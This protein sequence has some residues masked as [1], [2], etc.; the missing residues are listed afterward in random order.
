M[1]GSLAIEGNTLSLDQVTALL[2]GKRVAGP[3]REVREVQNALS[4]Y[5]QLPSLPP[6][7]ERSLLLM[8]RA[9][10]EGLVTDAGRW[11]RGNVGIFRRGKLRHLAP[12]AARV[13][14]LMRALVR[15]LKGDRHT[16]TLVRAC[17]AHY[18][19]QFIHP[20][21]DGNGRVGRLWQHV[22]LA[23]ESPVFALLPVESLIRRRQRAYYAA[24]ARADA[25]GESTPFI[26]FMLGCL[27]DSLEELI[28]EFRSAPKRREDR[29]AEAKR[30]LGAKWFSRKEYLTLFKSISTATAS[31][32]LQQGTAE[33][34]L[35]SR[36]ERALMR[37]R[38]AI[39]DR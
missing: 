7:S 6:W 9:L 27:V 12:P 32:D 5:S 34:R 22:I 33:R 4:A 39:S 24:L 13:P 35:I 29:L 8:H 38:F 1:Q 26:E 18:E 11:R 25:A 20:F 21:S 31:R 14:S 30:T 17:I 37:Y 23:N 16:P 3:A 28:R 2:E 10:M 19:L 15:S 36:G